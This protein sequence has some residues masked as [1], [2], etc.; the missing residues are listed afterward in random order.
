MTAWLAL[1]A[2]MLGSAI[3]FAA[4]SDWSLWTALAVILWGGVSAAVAVEID[5]KLRH[6]VP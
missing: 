1:V 3:W 5:R 6:K 2:A 4:E